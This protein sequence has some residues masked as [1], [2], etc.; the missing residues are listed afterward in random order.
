M[1]DTPECEVID[2]FS[3]KQNLEE[4]EPVSIIDEKFAS[5]SAANIATMERLRRERLKAN[6]S[7]LRSYQIKNR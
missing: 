5:E 4:D 7:V 1:D 3:R 2:I 6:K